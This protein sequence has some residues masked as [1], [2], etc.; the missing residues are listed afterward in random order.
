MKCKILDCGFHR[1]IRI[2]NG[3]AAW[4]ALEHNGAVRPA[5]RACLEHH[6]CR[7]GQGDGGPGVERAGGRSQKSEIWAGIPE[8]KI[9]KKG[10]GVGRDFFFFFLGGGGG[11]GGRGG[12]GVGWTPPPSLMQMAWDWISSSPAAITMLTKHFSVAWLMS[13][14]RSRWVLS[15]KY[16][17]NS[18]LCG[19]L[20][21]N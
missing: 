2:A 11:G 8:K 21:R 3:P 14:S 13:Y 15:R 10:T 1:G 5:Y 4:F 6:R 18:L 9:R 17:F 19:L 7:G 20:M 12:V 16:T